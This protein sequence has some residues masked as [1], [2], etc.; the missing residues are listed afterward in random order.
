MNVFTC[1]SIVPAILY[2]VLIL[3]YRYGWR[4]LP[5]WT[6]A[7]DYRPGLSITAVIPARNEAEHIG[8]CLSS[9]LVCDYPPEL[10]EI[11]VV[12]DYSEDGT[13]EVVRALMREELKTTPRLR[14]IRLGDYPDHS[15]NNRS[16][17]KKA[18]EIA[19][20]QARGEVILTTDADCIAPPGLLRLLASV[21]ENRHTTQMVAAPVVIH[22]EANLLQRFQ[23]LDL[24]GL[25]GVTGA[26]IFLGFQHMGN[27]ANLAY[28]KTAFEAVGGFA[29]NEHRAS[30]D[31][32][33]LVQKVAELYPNGIFFLKNPAAAVRTEAPPGLPGFL[34]QRLRW[35]SKN[36]ALRER[37][38][39]LALAAVWLY[40]WC[41]AATLILAFWRPATMLP[42]A[43]G[44]AGLKLT[45]D[46][47]H[48]RAMCRFFSRKD[49][50]R[51]YL[52]AALLHWLYILVVG[53]M[54]L[55]ARRYE[56][57]GRMVR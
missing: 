40:C 12:D 29:G 21:F 22:R 41:I 27:G 24:L 57:K 37:P 1:F 10:L 20:A 44:M 48:L 15:N 35:A 36:A 25:M 34:R 14:L 7:A 3:V 49:L 31:D 28:R 55:Q 50:L 51:Y 45:A 32:M 53:T 42:L 4:R 2:A 38:I 47:F 16:Y 18:L 19:I 13:A 43:A 5:V 56:W 8:E 39:R 6:P 46:W 17:K 23:S 54:G 9:I 26:G 11:I 30:G 52:P 33:F